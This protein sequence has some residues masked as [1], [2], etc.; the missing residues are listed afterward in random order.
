[1]NQQAYLS[2]LKAALEGLPAQVIADALAQAE[3]NIVDAKAQGKSEE[4]AVAA[5]DDVR[6][7]AARLRA[8]RNLKDFKQNANMYNFARVCA[9]LVGL[10]FLNMMLIG[11]IIAYFAILF[12]G[13]AVAFALFVGGSALTAS[14][15]TDL[16]KIGLDAKTSKELQ[17][18]IQREMKHA[19]ADER[20]FISIA[21]GEFSSRPVRIAVGLL[22]SLGSILMTLLMLFVT[23]YSL[24][25][26]RRYLIINWEILRG[27]PQAA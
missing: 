17:V 19:S 25:G 15:I 20:K 8:Q 23:K 12:A 18:E 21:A 7:V 26:L 24:L 14:G 6:Q 2:K 5:Q 11:P 13:Y 9:S 22:V 10:G 3:Q 27:Q 1:M 4:E 16:E